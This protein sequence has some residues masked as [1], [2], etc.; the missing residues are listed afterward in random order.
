MCCKADFSSL[1][2]KI[3]VTKYRLGSGEGKKKKITQ[4]TGTRSWGG[5]TKNKTSSKVGCVSY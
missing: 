2:K 4:E 1:R 5:D 3:K